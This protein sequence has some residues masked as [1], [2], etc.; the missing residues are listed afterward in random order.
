MQIICLKKATSA[1]AQ[2]H[3]NNNFSDKVNRRE[4]KIQNNFHHRP[5][6]NRDEA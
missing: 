5:S 2:V 1:S 6:I 4:H 3:R